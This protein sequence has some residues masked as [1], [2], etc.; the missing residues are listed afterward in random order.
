MA[1]LVRGFTIYWESATPHVTQQELV[2]LGDRPLSRSSDWVAHPWD[3]P[4]P[5]RRSAF[6]VRLSLSPGR[7]SVPWIPVCTC[8]T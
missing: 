7:L 6:H 1:S 3:A 4:L 2:F 5:R 8:S